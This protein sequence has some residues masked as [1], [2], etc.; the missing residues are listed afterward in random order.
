[1][2]R[3]DPSVVAEIKARLRIEDVVGRH[4]RLRRV[5]HRLVGPCP[6]HQETKPS[7]SVNPEEG[8]YYCFGCQAAGDVIEFYRA[9]HG[10]DFWDAVV[11]LAEEAGVELRLGKEGDRTGSSRKRLMEMQ[12]LAA[13]AFR[14]ALTAPLGKTARDYIARRGIDAAVVE[15]FSLGFAPAAWDFLW[16]K[17]RAAGFSAEEAALG[18]LVTQ[19]E[20]GG[21]YDR[22]R[23]RIM[24]PIWNLSGQVIAFGG[25]A[26][27]DDDG[28]KYLNSPET[29]LFTKGD[30]LYGLYQA[31]RA[32]S[33]QGRVLL[34][35]GYV[36]VLTLSQF[37]FS[38]S[39]GV[40]GTALTAEQVHRLAGFVSHVDVVMDGDGAGRKAAFRSAEMLL[41]QGLS[42]AVVELPEGED[43]DSFLRA[44]G[45]EALEELRRRAVDGVEYCVAWVRAHH[46]PAEIVAW[47]V[48]F[49]RAMKRLDLQA[50]FLPRIAG[51]LGLSEQELRR[52]L[53]PAQ[54]AM[55]AAAWEKQRGASASQ[56]DR[57]LLA[58]AI[59]FPHR[60]GELD[61]LGMESALSTPRG[62]DLWRKIRAQSADAVLPLLDAGEKAF[63]VQTQMQARQVDIEAAWESVCAWLRRHH[64]QKAVEQ[65]HHALAVAKRDGDLAE[66]LRLLAVL[67]ALKTQAV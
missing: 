65:I 44:Y 11:A 31:R 61:A 21:A 59:W 36:D 29:P 34:T 67:S 10:V 33:A 18:G 52:A 41:S 45:R 62:K 26:L 49:L 4:V 9:I 25:R 3:L 7:F 60:H 6:F 8:L 22:F 14:E 55:P 51:A 13:K 28:P 57:E 64:Q 30:H 1:M 58:V 50:Y 66:E 5:G 23:G 20:S 27:Q 35:E 38:A 15:A 17:L 56:R 12:A 46:N 19:K 24:F 40:L 47:A 53:A 16:R 39:C 63:Y 48:N 42:C 43:V 37:G 54:A 32:A 2:A